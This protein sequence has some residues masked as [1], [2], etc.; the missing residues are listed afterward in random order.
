[1]V[2][3]VAGPLKGG[4][5]VQR[6]QH[7]LITFSIPK[8]SLSALCHGG[9]ALDRLGLYEHRPTLFLFLPSPKQHA[10]S[11]VSFSEGFYYLFPTERQGEMMEHKK[12]VE[13]YNINIRTMLK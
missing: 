12:G 6:N 9:S 1:M 10:G 7:P 3:R 13:V 5:R 11:V 8:Y 2:E 4:G